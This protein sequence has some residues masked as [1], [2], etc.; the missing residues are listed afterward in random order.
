MAKPER[1]L[2][3]IRMIFPRKP[4]HGKLTKLPGVA[5]WMER[6]FFQGDH[7]IALPRDN[8]IR[9][10]RQVDDPGQTVL[11]TDLVDQFIEKS[12]DLWIMNFCI[13]RKS[14]SCRDYPT[15]L[16]CLFLGRATRGINPD[17]GRRVSREEAKEHIRKCQEKGLVHFMGR[18]KLDTVWLGIG[19]GERLLTIC[20]CCPCCCI[21]RG[22]PHSAPRLR[23]KLKRAPG[24]TVRVEE[25]CTGCG[26]CVDLEACFA[27]AIRMVAGQAIITEDC[28]G[29]GRCVE[30]CPNDAI[31]IT[32]DRDHFL[33]KNEEQLSRLVDLS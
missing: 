23:E 19:P 18:S 9:I 12:N 7:L 21:T 32:V 31:S 4:A 14:M 30:A 29:C 13:C 1:T 2:K 16:G 17:W 26:A 15:E 22:L 6:R 10:D 28:R 5:Q 33:K 20:N 8:V 24:V 27:R 11:P 3:F 25:S